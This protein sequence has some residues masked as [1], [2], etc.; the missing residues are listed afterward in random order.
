M[1]KTPKAGLALSDVRPK[2]QPNRILDTIS[3]VL[4][5][6]LPSLEPKPARQH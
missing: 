3:S 5:H 4:R 6:V 1:S 2:T